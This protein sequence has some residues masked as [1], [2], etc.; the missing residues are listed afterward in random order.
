MSGWAEAEL[1]CCSHL[2][3]ES[4]GFSSRGRTH[5]LL[6][7][8]PHGRGRP[9]R[10]TRVPSL[11]PPRCWQTKGPAWVD[12][13]PQCLIPGYEFFITELQE[14]WQK[15]TELCI[16]CTI[17]YLPCLLHYKVSKSTPISDP[18]DKLT[19]P[20]NSKLHKYF[21]LKSIMIIQS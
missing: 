15:I 10:D 3:L 21:S 11:H 6:P 20:E 4:V 18:K 19:V 16:S 17:W 9:A 12:G 14:A 2:Q 7:I 1:R 5:I 13:D 8:C